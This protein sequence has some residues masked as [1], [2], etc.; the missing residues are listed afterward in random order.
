MLL[1]AERVFFGKENTGCKGCFL[2]NNIQTDGNVRFLPLFWLN[3]KISL[4]TI[5]EIYITISADKTR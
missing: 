4:F 5:T 3:G 2:Q 1:K